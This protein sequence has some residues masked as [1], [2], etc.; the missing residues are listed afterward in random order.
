[1][2]AL[3]KE[4]WL[5][6]IPE[7]IYNLKK[8][9]GFY[10]NGFQIRITKD[11]LEVINP[12]KHKHKIVLYRRGQRFFLVVYRKNDTIIYFTN[13]YVNDK[14]WNR[15]RYFEKKFNRAYCRAERELEND[16]F[17]GDSSK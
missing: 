10:Y 4:E 7:L 8:N 15:I 16:L 13:E 11:I 3:T 1:M 9:Y 17:K 6:D 12:K 5:Q 14:N 2:K